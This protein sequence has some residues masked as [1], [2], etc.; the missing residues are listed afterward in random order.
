MHASELPRTPTRSR[1]VDPSGQQERE[2]RAVETA[3]FSDRDEILTYREAAELL[4][5]SARTLERWTRESLVPYIRLPQR[6][7]WSGVRFSRTQL[8][9]GLRRRTVTAR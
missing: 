2:P 8:L 5:V 7:R 9:R 3:T 4:N 1:I 6:G